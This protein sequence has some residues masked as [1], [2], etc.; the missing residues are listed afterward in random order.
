MAQ[1]LDRSPGSMVLFFE[2]ELRHL[3]IIYFNLK[4]KAKHH[5]LRISTQEPV[6]SDL[7]EYSRVFLLTSTK[8]HAGDFIRDWVESS[9]QYEISMTGPPSWQEGRKKIYEILPVSKPN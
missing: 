5:F 8:H 9:E 3:F 1:L 7:T 6:S 4:D 2:G